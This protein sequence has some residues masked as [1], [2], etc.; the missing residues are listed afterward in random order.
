LHE[1]SRPTLFLVTH[2]ESL[3]NRCG[4]IVRLKDGRIVA[5]AR[6]A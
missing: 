5:D 3:A 4:R 2:E 6:A 1:R